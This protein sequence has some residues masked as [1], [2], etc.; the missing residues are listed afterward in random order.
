MYARTSDPITSH[1]TAD[2]ITRSGIRSAQCQRVYDALRAHPGRTSAEL[3]R[4]MGCDRYI[5]GRRLPEL[6]REGLAAQ[7]IKRNCHVKGRASM[8]WWPL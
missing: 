8:T 6:R 7:G 4:W 5:P 1:E 2:W 3:A